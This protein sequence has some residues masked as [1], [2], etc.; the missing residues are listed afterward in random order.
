VKEAAEIVITTLS[1]I[2]NAPL[3]RRSIFEFNKS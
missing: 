1:T 2:K 3:I